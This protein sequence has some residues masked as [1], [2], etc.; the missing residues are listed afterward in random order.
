MIVFIEVLH[1]VKHK[2]TFTDF[3]ESNTSQSHSF[4]ILLQ[5]IKVETKFIRCDDFFFSW[6]R[7]LF[8]GNDFINGI[9]VSSI[10]PIAATFAGYSD[11]GFY[12]QIRA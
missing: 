1:F 2:K 10:F 8:R 4:L 5:Q 12:L 9:N 3:K 6:K 11:V 7:V